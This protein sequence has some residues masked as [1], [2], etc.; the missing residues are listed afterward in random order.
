M[1][2]T[3]PPVRTKWSGQLASPRAAVFIRDGP[4]DPDGLAEPG[5]RL[6]NLED[7]GRTTFLKTLRET[8]DALGYGEQLNFLDA[9]TGRAEMSLG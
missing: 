1:S 4:D 9:A 5:F 6:F 2:C 7:D 8:F 3:W